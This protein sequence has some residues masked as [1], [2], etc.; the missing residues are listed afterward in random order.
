MTT[1]PKLDRKELKEPDQFQVLSAKIIE[2]VNRNKNIIATICF[3]I[4]IGLAG[5][6]YFLDKQKTNNLRMESLYFEMEQLREKNKDQPDQLIQKLK[7]KLSEFD[8]GDQKQRAA[9]I[10]ADVYYQNRKYDDAITI[11]SDILNNTS[12]NKLDYFLAQNGKAHALE[13][14]KK[15]K[16]AIDIF[17]SLVDKPS[18]FP[19]FY[20]YLGLAR[21]YESNGD[22]KNA[23]LILREIKSKY[24]DHEG[25]EKV[26]SIL[27][28]LEGS[29]G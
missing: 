12:A 19:L 9:L 25:L 4:L 24:T 7:E 21:C 8:K 15:Y 27:K 5:A 1:T 22:S 13:G 10:L 20:I 18:K 28:R 14:Q 2:F 26:D 3:L 23:V 17:K 16:E 11:Y 6:W 29:V